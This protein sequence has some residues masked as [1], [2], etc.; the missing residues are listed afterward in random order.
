MASKLSGGLKTG[1][2]MTIAVIV[3]PLAMAPAAAAPEVVR[4]FCV[5]AGQVCGPDRAS[6]CVPVP[7]CRDFRVTFQSEG[8]D[9]EARLVDTAYIREQRIAL[10]E[11]LSPVDSLSDIEFRIAA[12]NP[13]GDF[14]VD[15]GPL[16][17]LCN[18]A[19][20][21]YGISAG[22]QTMD[23]PGSVTRCQTIFDCR[24]AKADI[25]VIAGHFLFESPYV[26]SLADIWAGRMGLNVAIVDVASISLYS[27][28]LI[29][30]FIKGV[31]N[32]ASAEHFG[33]GRVGFVVLLGDAYEN[34]NLHS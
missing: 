11:I 32:T 10:F 7:D 34:D 4:E 1:V 15:T 9:L 28:T 24:D 29:R 27:P 3:T 21:G 18:S 5:D 23:G 31:Y 17:R 20:A 6:I 13:I 33:D 26:D 14:C 12:S 30:D 25:L 22:H 16:T 2:V 19:L 8:H